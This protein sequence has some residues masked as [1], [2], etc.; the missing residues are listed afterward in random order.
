MSG[1]SVDLSLCG[2]V[3]L[4]RGVDQILPYPGSPELREGF[5]RHAGDYVRLVE[6]R[7]S[8]VPVPAGFSWPWGDALRALETFR[9]D[10]RVLNLE[11]SVTSS[12]TFAPG[13]GIHYRMA[14]ANLPCLSAARPD[15][16][17]LANNHVMDFG[18]PGLEETLDVLAGAGL[19]TAGAGRDLEGARRPAV[20]P[21][22]GPGPASR[23]LTFAMGTP[24]SGVPGSWAA[25]ESRPGV[26][27]LPVLSESSAAELSS[28]VRESRRPGDVV[29]VSVHWGSNWGYAVP[30]EQTRFAHALIDGGGADVVF[31]HS[32]H[33]PRPV[34]IY[35]G[36]L[37]LYGCGDFIDDYEGITGYEEYRDELRLL[38]LATVD[39]ATGRLARLRAVP[40]TSRRMRLHRAAAA[41]AAWLRA[42]L[43]EI[44]RDFGVRAAVGDDAVLILE[45]ARR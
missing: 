25:T 44:S 39:T 31:G 18:V 22:A 30:P 34:E 45:A 38:Y 32:S 23:V 2:D 5:T 19:R 4:G 28:R 29:V 3:M 26:D 11:T 42:V 33:H 21:L 20:V 16:C 9:P 35:R 43:D 13:K 6:A 8:P 41:D 14:P 12:R 36:K 24:S 27:L 7:S 40:F 1:E 15:V 10:V 17:V 37:V